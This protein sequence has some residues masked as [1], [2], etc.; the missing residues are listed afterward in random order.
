MN[1]ME[2]LLQEK[3]NYMKEVDTMKKNRNEIVT[4]LQENNKLMV[5]QLL[6]EMKKAL[7]NAE[8]QI[9]E[10]EKRCQRL[11]DQ[12]VRMEDRF[13]ERMKSMENIIN[14]LESRLCEK[15]KESVK[16]EDQM[17]RM[18]DKFEVRIKQ[19]EV[20]Q[21]ETVRAMQLKPLPLPPN[22]QTHVFLTHTWREDEKGRN[23]HDRVGRVN[24][25]LRKRGLVTWFDSERM[26]G[27]VRQAMTDALDGTCCVLIFITKKYEEKVNS[28][29]EADNCYF[30]FNVAAHDKNLAN[31]RIPIVMEECMLSQEGWQGGGRLKAEMGHK[32]YF[33]L[34]SDE[35]GVLEVQYD[36]IVERVVELLK[37]RFPEVP[38][39]KHLSTSSKRLSRQFNSSDKKNR[40]VNSGQYLSIVM[41][42][43]RLRFNVK[44]MFFVMIV[45]LSLIFYL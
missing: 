7:N 14:N 44:I 4:M 37:E 31:M 45:A 1:E 34:C 28:K 29:N 33:D 43:E 36:K 12:V 22:K 32:I 23:N 30:E 17:I 11:E 40:N 16:L 41:W 9:D 25:A 15:E 18:E 13:E 10:K 27:T 38:F 2:R 42:Y 21:K 26:S 6:S 39:D 19:M 24:E 5:D 20:S 3:E 35:E 8:R